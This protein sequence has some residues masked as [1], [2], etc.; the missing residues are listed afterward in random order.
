LMR[1]VQR[2]LEILA[3]QLMRIKWSAQVSSRATQSHAAPDANR[4]SGF[5][6][7]CFGAGGGNR[8]R[9]FSLEN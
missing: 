8:T 1:W 5:E 6:R 2:P 7:K 4:C 3:K 9:I